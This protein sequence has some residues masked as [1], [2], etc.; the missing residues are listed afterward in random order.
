MPQ[1]TEKAVEWIGQQS[2]ER[3][4][5]L[6][7]PFTSPHAPIVPAAEFEGTSSARGYGDFVVQTDDAVG[8]VLAALEAGGFSEQTLVIFT[9]DNGPETYAYERVRRC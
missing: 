2:S 3:P 6:Y 7:F 5:F 4:F 9:S 8:R 1:L